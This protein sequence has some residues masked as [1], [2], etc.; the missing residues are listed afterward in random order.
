MTSSLHVLNRGDRLRSTA[1][2]TD[3]PAAAQIPDLSQQL[4]MNW[5]IDSSQP[6][7]DL[8]LNVDI[9]LDAALGG[10]DWNMAPLEHPQLG[11]DACSHDIVWDFS[12]TAEPVIDFSTSANSVSVCDQVVDGFLDSAGP[13]DCVTEVVTASDAAASDIATSSL[14]S[15]LEFRRA[16]QLEIDELKAF[17]TQ[18][19]SELR[20]DDQS[21]LTSWLQMQS[22][23]LN[24]MTF[25]GKGDLELGN[26]LQALEYAESL[27]QGHRLRQLSL[28][29][30]NK[31]F[32][33]RCV[34][35]HFV[36]T[37][38]RD[39]KS[40]SRRTIKG[41]MKHRERAAKLDTQ[42][43]DTELKRAEAV[44]I[45]AEVNLIIGR[46]F[47]IILYNEYFPLDNSKAG[48]SQALDQDT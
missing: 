18:R 23:G 28:L 24:K 16:L 48:G 10:V 32:L 27:L 15:S 46:Y 4:D 19:R 37:K 42:I 47:D 33:D 12:S 31:G 45:I 3:A 29:E 44:S 39:W 41:I 22:G 34:L 40:V 5:T 36:C 25:L 20:V 6:A 30:C 11:L 8:N 1:K 2:N 17:F 26:Y 14:L 13:S 7:V 43:A 35:V 38:D 21:L 9:S